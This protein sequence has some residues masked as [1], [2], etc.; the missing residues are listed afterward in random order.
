MTWEIQTIAETLY[1]L[2][3]DLVQEKPLI[4]FKKWKRS[5]L[6]QENIFSI[7]SVGTTYT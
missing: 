6:Q 1:N 2:F 7:L 3:L 4:W 5:T